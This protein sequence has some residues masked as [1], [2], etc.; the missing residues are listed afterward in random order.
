MIINGIRSFLKLLILVQ[1]RQIMMSL[2]KKFKI[3][4]GHLS[5]VISIL[6]IQYL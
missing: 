2:F 6:E 3:I 5:M 1:V 4:N